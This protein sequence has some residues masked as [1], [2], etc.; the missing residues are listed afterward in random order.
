MHWHPDAYLSYP[1]TTLVPSASKSHDKKGKVVRTLG[2][3]VGLRMEMNSWKH[4]L[5]DPP[6]ALGARQIT[7]KDQIKSGRMALEVQKKTFEGYWNVAVAPCIVD[8]GEA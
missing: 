1:Q 3:C 6:S 4:T 8:E 5:R 7:C 2:P